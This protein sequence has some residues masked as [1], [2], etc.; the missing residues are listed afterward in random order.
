MYN[1]YDGLISDIRDL[2]QDIQDKVNKDI[3]V[4]FIF[5]NVLCFIVSVISYMGGHSTFTISAF[6]L[7]IFGAFI[8]GMPVYGIIMMC[9][10]GVR[11]IKRRSFAALWWLGLGIPMM[12]FYSDLFSFWHRVLFVTIF[13]AEVFYANKTILTMKLP[14]KVKIINIPYNSAVQQYSRLHK[15][16]K[17]RHQN[18]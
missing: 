2:E 13:L 4:T 3:G 14:K 8:V 11:A 9:Q 18:R 15:K 5:H 17:N 6:F 16:H 1:R 10:V 7:C 12:F